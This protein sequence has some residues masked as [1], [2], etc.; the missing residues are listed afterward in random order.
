MIDKSSKP[1]VY[2]RDMDSTGVLKLRTYRALCKEVGKDIADEY[3]VVV[4]PLMGRDVRRMTRRYVNIRLR[5]TIVV[6]GGV[7]HRRRFIQIVYQGLLEQ[8]GLP[9]ARMFWYGVNQKDMSN[10]ELQIYVSGW[11]H[12]ETKPLEDSTGHVTAGTET[13]LQ[14]VERP[15]YE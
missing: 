7:L 6:H 1:N 5:P 4:S 15:L 13:I 11:A 14:D 10:E 3:M 12:I 8:A 9:E 2:L